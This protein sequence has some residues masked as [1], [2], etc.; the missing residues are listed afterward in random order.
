[1]MYRDVYDLAA[2]MCGSRVAMPLEGPDAH[3]W[4]VPL[5]HRNRLAQVMRPLAS[6]NN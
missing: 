6:V 2:T 1:M 4:F 3:S 5:F